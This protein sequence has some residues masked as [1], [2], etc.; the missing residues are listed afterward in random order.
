MTWENIKQNVY[1]SDG[2]LRDIYVLDSTQADWEKWIN[3]INENYEV[4]FTY[5]NEEGKEISNNKIDFQKVVEYWENTLDSVLNAE[6]LINKV[7]FKCYF[8]SDTE[9]ENDIWPN[10]VGDLEQ[11]NSIVEYMMTISK[12]LGKEIFMAPENYNE[13]SEYKLVVV[14]NEDVLIN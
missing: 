8:F 4:K 7:V 10:D 14:N 11:H 9:I 5:Y 12:L 13:S 2:S 3:Y 6:F 1:Y